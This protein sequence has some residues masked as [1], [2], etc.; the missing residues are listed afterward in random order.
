MFTKTRHLK[1]TLCLMSLL[2]SLPTFA[3]KFVNTSGITKVVIPAAG[4]GTRFMPFTKT[5]P[6]ELLPILN[7]PAID[8]IVEECL[9]A[10]FNDCHIIINEDKMA[11]KEYLTQDGAIEK[12]IKAAGKSHLLAP[13][14]N[15]IKHAT[16]TYIDQ[17]EMKGL[18]HAI[19]MAKPYIQQE[20]FGVLLPDM[21]FV[22]S[23]SIMQQ[24]ALLAKEYNASVI[25]VQK[26]APE[27]ISAYGSIK[28]GTQINDR[29]FE[30]I[31]I[32]EKPKNAA[33][34]PSL[35]AIAG[36]YVFSPAIFDAIEK[37]APMARG[38]IQLTDAMV[39]LAQHGERVLVYEIS[40]RFFDT[41]R[42]HGWLEANIYFGIHSEEYG[43]YI[44]QSIRDFEANL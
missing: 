38:E 42:P 34:A 36:R 7:R 35:Y 6:K 33:Q 30:M 44:K 29:L 37:I 14:N 41:G 1:I 26:V 22:E 39:Y 12:K 32:V 3:K 17:T 21:L 2:V 43:D 9:Q 18:G 4:Y 15:L 8:L 25:A 28:L 24:L 13:T 23:D 19:L 11:I 16:F 40:G 10:G 31:D 20:F 5:V 27:E